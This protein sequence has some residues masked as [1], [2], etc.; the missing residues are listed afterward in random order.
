MSELLAELE[1]IRQKDENNMADIKQEFRS[2]KIG[3]KYPTTLDK[4]VQK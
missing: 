1:S 2:L 4:E 3:I